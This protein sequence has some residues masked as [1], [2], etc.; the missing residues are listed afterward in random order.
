MLPDLVEAEFVP[1]PRP[2]PSAE[3][4]LL[5]AINPQARDSLPR[6]SEAGR[7]KTGAVC[8][9]G[10]RGAPMAGTVSC[11]DTPR[12]FIVF[13][14]HANKKGDRHEC[15]RDTRGRKPCTGSVESV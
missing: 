11:E 5:A 13:V 8:S 14:T 3:D 7:T 10:F 2:T 9:R 15:Q 12:R 1:I 6:R 4:G